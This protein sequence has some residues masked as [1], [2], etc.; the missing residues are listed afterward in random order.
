MEHDAQN[1][2]PMSYSIFTTKW[3]TILGA[4]KVQ[5]YRN[6]V[7]YSCTLQAPKMVLH[8]IVN[9]EYDTGAPF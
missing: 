4:R 8:F 7:Y 1:G 6:S 3:S 9:V 5:L 2:A